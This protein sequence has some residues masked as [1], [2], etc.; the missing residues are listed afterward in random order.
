VI[1]FSEEIDS[2]DT[3][4]ILTPEDEELPILISL[5]REDKL[6]LITPAQEDFSYFIRIR[7][8]KDLKGNVTPL[9]RVEYRSEPELDSTPPEVAFSSP[10]NGTSVDTLEPILEVHFSEIIPRSGIS[11]SLRAAQS[12]TE[13]PMDILQSDNDIYRFQARQPLQNYRSYV[14]SVS[15]R[16]ISGNQMPQTFELNFLPLLRSE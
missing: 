11:A 5:L 15:A 10:R 2:Y 6:T 12:S 16:D 4:K 8:L 13:I 3:V 7:G 9:Q 14:L 1:N